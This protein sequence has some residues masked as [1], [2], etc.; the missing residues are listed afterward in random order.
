MDAASYFAMQGAQNDADKIAGE[1][2]DYLVATAAVLT[3][4]VEAT[5]LL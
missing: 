4:G 3:T 2:I 5:H 1:D